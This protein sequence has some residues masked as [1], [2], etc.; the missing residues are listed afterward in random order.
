MLY[1]YK[2]ELC[3]TNIFQVNA[4]RRETNLIFFWNAPHPPNHSHPSPF[5]NVQSQPDHFWKGI[6]YRPCFKTD[7]QPRI[8]MRRRV[9]VENSWRNRFI[10]GWQGSCFFSLTFQYIYDNQKQTLTT[11]VYR[12]GIGDSRRRDV[13][14]SVHVWKPRFPVDWRLLV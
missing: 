14:L 12:P 10:N 11:Y 7:Q 13:R 3:D 2:S 1:C 5:N 6:S 4:K 8:G 9:Q